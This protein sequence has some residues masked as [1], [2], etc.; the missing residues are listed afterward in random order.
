MAVLDILTLP[1]AQRAVNVLGDLGSVE[2]DLVAMVSGVSEQIDNLCGPVVARAV[3]ETYRG[4]CSSILFRTTPVLSV[5]SVVETTGVTPATL[6]AADYLLEN[7]GHY[8]V[9][10]RRSAGYASFWAA[11]DFNVAVTFQ[12]GRFA[13]TAAVSAGWK[14]VAASILK[15]QWQQESGAW[16]QRPDAFD[17]YEN[18]EV[19]P[20]VSVGDMLRRRLPYELLPPGVA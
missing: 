7:Q 9:L 1:E 2:D 3:T 6:V 13:T 10:H 14:Q 8:A 15:A 12:A 11:G 16:S 17:T 18:G 19:T 4:G 5:T 20:F